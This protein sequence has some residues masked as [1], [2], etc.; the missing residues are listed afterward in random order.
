[1]DIK[2]K[3]STSVKKKDIGRTVTVGNSIREKLIYYLECCS[4]VLK[5][6]GVNFDLKSMR[7]APMAELA[8][9]VITLFDIETMVSLKVFKRDDN[10]KGASN[11]FFEETP[12][13]NTRITINNHVV[14]INK[15]FKPTKVNYVT[16]NWYQ[17]YY[18]NPLKEALKKPIIKFDQIKS[19]RMMGI[20]STARAVPVV[21]VNPQ[22]DHSSS[23]PSI[24]TGTCVICLDHESD[25]IAIP[26]GHYMYCDNCT[27]KL[28]NICSVC[29]GKV[30]EW[31]RVYK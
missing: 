10:L 8:G 15:K 12:T 25:T 6:A 4:D 21:K 2:I 18:L 20:V 29:R 1:M 11:K 13:T 30:T 24:P 23:A 5:Q 3:H 16:K 7:R 17:K 19:F 22:A 9:A 28:K 31:K 14:K 26:C 27:K